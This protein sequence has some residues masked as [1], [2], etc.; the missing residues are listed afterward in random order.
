MV[1]GP[2]GM[3][4][5]PAAGAGFF[6][7][8]FKRPHRWR[9]A[10]RSVTLRVPR[11]L[12]SVFRTR[13]RPGLFMQE[14]PASHRTTRAQCLAAADRCTELLS[15]GKELKRGAREMLEA[16]ARICGV[17][18]EELALN[19]AYRRQ[20]CALCAVLCRACHDECRQHAGELFE[21]CAEACVRAAWDCRAT[22]LET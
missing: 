22:A 9:R 5:A 11:G 6:P 12:H 16:C 10:A 17:A 13:P 21:H 3:S 19:S 1:K 14:I 18:A 4:R 20:V 15:L 2:V 8:R 7:A